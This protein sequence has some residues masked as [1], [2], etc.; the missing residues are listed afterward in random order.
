MEKHSGA[1]PACFSAAHECQ[2]TLFRRM[3]WCFM[4]VS[5]KWLPFLSVDDKVQITTLILITIKFNKSPFP[6][7]CQYNIYMSWVNLSVFTIWF[8][9]KIQSRKR[10]HCMA[11]IC[12]CFIFAV[13]D[14]RYKSLPVCW[15]ILSLLFKRGNLYRNVL[16]HKVI[17]SHL[18]SKL[19]TL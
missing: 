12:I 7:P 16:K 11:F 13:F 17:V 10:R 2:Q 9:V 5:G 19:W 3:H 1:L 6:R 4:H 14:I 18:L 15:Q 8:S